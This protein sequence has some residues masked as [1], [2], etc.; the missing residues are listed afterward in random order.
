MSENVV[1]KKLPLM[2]EIND[3]LTIEQCN[4]LI[5]KIE[6]KDTISEDIEIVTNEHTS[7]QFRIKFNDS[8]IQ[9]MV[10]NAKY[11]KDY[12]VCQTFSY[13]RY[14]N[15]GYIQTHTDSYN[16]SNVLY[17]LIMY[18]NDDYEN[19]ETYFMD[20]H[21]KITIQKKTGKGFLF[22]GSQMHHGCHKVDGVKRIL[23][24]KLC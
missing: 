12:N 24:A 20:N 10:Q 19:G 23:I 1:A 7:N 15:G 11:C 21:K 2:I 22:V 4:Q 14:E 3:L 8:E 16:E 17:T 18:L 9:N 5:E 13:V 6:K